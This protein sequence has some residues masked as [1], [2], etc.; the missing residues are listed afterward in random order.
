VGRGRQQRE[1]PPRV[2]GVGRL[3]EQRVTERDDG[4]GRE[5]DVLRVPPRDGSGLGD[6]EV[7]GDLGRE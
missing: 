4:V 2:F 3:A 5:H 1:H 6:R 7:F